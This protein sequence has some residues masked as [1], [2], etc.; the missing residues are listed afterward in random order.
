M[1]KMEKDK[2]KID[3]LLDCNAAEQ[4]AEVDW[5]KLNAAISNQLDQTRTYKT[6]ERKHPVIFKIIW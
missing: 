1:E 4:L 2:E 5:D 3:S 6:S